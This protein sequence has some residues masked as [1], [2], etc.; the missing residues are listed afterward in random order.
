MFP[1]TVFPEKKQTIIIIDVSKSSTNEP[2]FNYFH[3]QTTFGNNT[4]YQEFMIRKTFV[5]LLK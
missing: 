4:G 1:G 3:V 2:R 5:I